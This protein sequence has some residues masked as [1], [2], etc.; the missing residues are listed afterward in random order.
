MKKAL[1]GKT[2]VAIVE[3]I[4]DPDK[5]GRVKARVLDVYDDMKLEDIP[6]ANPWKDL[7][8]GQFGLPELGKV[9]IVVFDTGDSNK[10][11]YISS[12][13]WNVNLENK[14][15]SISE[16]DYASMRSL[17][18]D[19][20]TQI[21]S[22]DSEGLKLDYKFNNVNV[23]DNSINLN[24][25]DNNMSLNLGDSTADQQAILGNHWVNWFDRFV[26][27]L[28]Q[29]TAFVGNAGAP[30]L[31]SPKLLSLLGEFKTLKDS[32][33]LSHHVN[34]VDNNKV[35]TVKNDSRLE[36]AQAG[37]EWVST[38][39]ENI[40]T[41]V[42]GDTNK[43]VDG[44]KEKYDENFS[45]PPITEPGALANEPIPLKNIEPPVDKS[46]VSSNKEIEKLVWFMNVK[47]YEIF[48][49]KHHL[50][51]IGVRST[52]KIEG[53]VTNLFDEKLYVFYRNINNNWEL[54]EFSITT[55]P[56]YIPGTEQLP[57]DVAMLRLGQYV[58][59]LKLANFGGDVNHK[60][61][62]FELCA[63]HK[64]TEPDFYDWD[65]EAFVGPFPISI[66]RSTNKSTSEFVFNYSEGSQ[67]FKNRNQYDLFIKL[68][69]DQINLGKK[70]KF[71]YTLISQK[72][73]DLYPSPDEQ[74]KE[75]EGVVANIAQQPKIN[76]PD[77]DTTVNN[78]KNT[79]PIS[80]SEISN[81]INDLIK[82]GFETNTSTSLQ[83]WVEDEDF[84]TTIKSESAG[85]NISEANQNLDSKISRMV[86]DNPEMYDKF[87][88]KII[89]G[90]VENGIRV[91]KTLE[92]LTTDQVSKELS[93]YD[94]FKDTYEGL[95]Q[96]VIV[97]FIPFLS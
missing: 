9:V 88:Y 86:S 84:D 69:E 22:T 91:Y 87:Y 13:H 85:V 60:C 45:E 51:I 89:S 32:K 12:E 78:A 25:K 28:I 15:K 2:Y 31:S 55:V 57:K 29:N 37:D 74:R 54:S 73:F 23:K 19:H 35:S 63:I 14:L 18:F 33:F 39:Q 4:N 5:S 11:E 1:P 97:K 50:N 82:N 17:V 58:E 92:N 96:V 24:L 42:S 47:K 59:Q 49:Q 76:G 62:L 68:C 65:S 48:E 44:E 26:D 72:E 20:K 61:L 94:I 43:P 6:W 46:S 16:S 53:D 71:S 21:Y 38:R 8:G 27:E 66:H 41:S 34:I 56:G 10:P 67:V 75:T 95:T 30:V 90:P 79:K 80:K 64:N 83:D 77:I 3:D 52:N 81:F 7:V 40:I 36:T 93:N 70:D